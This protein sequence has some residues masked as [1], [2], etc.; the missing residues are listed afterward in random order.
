MDV[1]L[2]GGVFVAAVLASYFFCIR[3]MRRGQ[4]AMKPQLGDRDEELRRLREE[5]DRLK[6]E[7]SQG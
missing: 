2:A 4:C 6:R 5:V 3:P 1:L 7:M